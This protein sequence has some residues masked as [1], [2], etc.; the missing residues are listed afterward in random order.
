MTAANC[1]R[2][3][4]Y[5]RQIPLITSEGQDRI[6]QS[7]VLVVGAGGLGSIC[8]Y[9]LAAAGIGTIGIIDNDVV[10]DHNLNRQFIHFE[11]D[12]SRPKVESAA[13]KLGMFNSD[14]KINTHN[15]F[16][17]GSNIDAIAKDYQLIMDC[18]DNFSTKYL[19]NDYCIKAGR[20][21]FLSSVLGT[22]GY[23]MNII[24]DSTACLRC[25]FPEYVQKA[26]SDTSSLMFEKS[27]NWGIIGSVVGIVASI[28]TSEC[29]LFIVNRNKALRNKML[30]VKSD[31][32][33]ISTHEMHA[34][35]TCT[36][37][38]G[39]RTNIGSLNG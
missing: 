15:A 16:L 25:I 11:N 6:S 29:I 28:Q 24:P 18:S 10:A 31:P 35:E 33:Q 13:E 21:L 19:L 23:Q 26:E 37:N 30:Y 17:A 20:P 12:I 3:N 27:D 8:L 39:K 4:R 5:S 34:A 38:A 36:C 14:I 1:S 22:E 2:S 32:L 7:S 9:Y